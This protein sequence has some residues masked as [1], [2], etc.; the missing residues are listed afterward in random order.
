MHGSVI[1]VLRNVDQIQSILS[2]LPHDGATIGVFL[3]RHL[4]YKSPYMLRNVHSN[5][6]RV[7]YKILLK[8]DKYIECYHSSS[9]GEFVY[10]AYEFRISNSYL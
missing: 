3:K 5:M 4:E 7:V 8:Q 10:F 2:H 9:M 1:N 6:V